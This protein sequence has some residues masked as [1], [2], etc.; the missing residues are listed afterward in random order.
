MKIGEKEIIRLWT[1]IGKMKKIHRGFKIERKRGE[2]IECDLIVGKKE[3]ID[4]DL[5]KGT[6]EARKG[7][8]KTKL[9]K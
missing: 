9:R 4:E 8:R 5:M 7:V 3:R 2:V 6:R 1:T